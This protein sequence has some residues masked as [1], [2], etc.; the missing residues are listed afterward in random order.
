MLVLAIDISPLLDETIPMKVAFPSCPIPHMHVH[1]GEG[2]YSDAPPNNNYAPLSSARTAAKPIFCIQPQKLVKTPCSGKIFTFAMEKQNIKK[3]RE[4]VPSSQTDKCV[5]PA[6]WLVVCSNEDKKLF[7]QFTLSVENLSRLHQSTLYKTASFY[8]ALCFYKKEH[9]IQRST[10]Y[11]AESASVALSYIPL[12]QTNV[13]TSESD[14]ISLLRY[15][16]LC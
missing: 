4:T 7:D 6:E 3:K 5:F 1:G 13:N 14:W 16:F 8:N 9:C 15:I 12:R 11:K 10:A 2:G